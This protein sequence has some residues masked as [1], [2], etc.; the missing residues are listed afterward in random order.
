MENNELK[1]LAKI[2]AV[3]GDMHGKEISITLINLYF[4]Q[5]KQFPMSDIRRA[6]SSPSKWFPKPFDVIELI[7]GSDKEIKEIENINL[8]IQAGEQAD[9]VLLHLDDHGANSSP[10]F[11]DPI[12]AH[13]M[14]SV[15]PYRSWGRQHLT[16]NNIFFRRDFVEAYTNY[17]KTERQQLTHDEAKQ[18]LERIK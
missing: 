13:I 4:E 11:T 17:N 8:G 10:E 15:F 3:I 12:T 1:E 14:S 9:M 6:L 5:L 18:L 16:K 7:Q 2:L